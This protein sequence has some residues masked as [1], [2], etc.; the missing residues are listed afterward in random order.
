MAFSVS[1]LGCWVFFSFRIYWRGWRIKGW[2][3]LRPCSKMR[4]VKLNITGYWWDL[5][6]TALLILLLPCCWYPGVEPVLQF[7]IIC[8]TGRSSAYLS[9][10]CWRVCIHGC[11]WEGT[12]LPFSLYFQSGRSF[13][14]RSVF[15]ISI[16]GSCSPYIRKI[17]PAKWHKVLMQ[18]LC[19]SPKTH[20]GGNKEQSVIWDINQDWFFP[21]VYCTLFWNIADFKS[22]P[23]SLSITHPMWQVEE[24]GSVLYMRFAHGSDQNQRPSQDG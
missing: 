21:N 18:K 17:P 9:H 16:Q 12:S 6:T 14:Y 5:L 24:E 7:V 4:I 1:C 19:M 10:F 22:D 13:H 8:L 20:K 3:W 23:Y 11:V 2:E 15:I